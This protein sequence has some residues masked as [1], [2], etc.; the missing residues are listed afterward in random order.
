MKLQTTM[1]YCLWI[2]VFC[3]NLAG[4]GKTVYYIVLRDV[5]DTPSFVV[6]P[7]NNTMA[8]VSYA[9]VIERAILSA[10]VKVELRPASKEVEKTTVDASNKRNTTLSRTE[11]YFAL[12]ELTADYL[13]QTYATPADVKIS[14]LATPDG[15]SEVLTIVKV[16]R[17]YNAP[18]GESPIYSLRVDEKSSCVYLH[19][20]FDCFL[21]FP[22]PSLII[23]SIFSEIHMSIQVLEIKGYLLA[24]H[25]ICF[26]STLPEMS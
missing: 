11:R 9:N 6:I 10:G 4:C 8:E 23:F 14:K 22:N 7:A 12:D 5:P 24:L 21:F 13:V 2:V 16:S 19:C 25:T 3:L 18:G 1:C 26:F 20:I 17:V 15:V